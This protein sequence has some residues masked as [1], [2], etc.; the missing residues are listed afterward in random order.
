LAIFFL[1]VTGTFVITNVAIYSEGQRRKKQIWGTLG[2][3]A[4]V[5]AIL[6]TAWT[7]NGTKIQVFEKKDGY[8]YDDDD[9]MLIGGYEQREASGGEITVTLDSITTPETP[10]SGSYL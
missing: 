5:N 9:S 7:V 10:L 1:T 2:T 8:G 4:G 3:E 6:S